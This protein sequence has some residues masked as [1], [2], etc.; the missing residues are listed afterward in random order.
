M[1]TTHLKWIAISLSTLML[2][3]SCNVYHSKTSTVDDAI[4]YNSKIKAVTFYDDTYKFHDLIREEG[5]LYGLA[6]KYSTT[7]KKLETL[8]VNETLG[9]RYVKISVL[10]NTI[11]GYYLKNKTVSTILTGIAFIPVLFIMWTVIVFTD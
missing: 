1:K 11:K 10:E 3:Q 6:K 4:E 5:Q 2:M 9:D 7:A 8:I